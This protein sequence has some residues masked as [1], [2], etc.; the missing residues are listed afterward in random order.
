MSKNRMSLKCKKTQKVSKS[1]KS[2]KWEQHSVHAYFLVE[3][4]LLGC[5]ISVYYLVACLGLYTGG[6]IVYACYR[7][8]NGLYTTV[9][10]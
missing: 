8:V 10:S 9:P 4:C 1:I 6:Y 3:L 5:E 2:V 7:V